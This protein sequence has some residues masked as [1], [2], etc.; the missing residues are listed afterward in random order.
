MAFGVRGRSG[1][2]GP[3]DS[4]V[5][6]NRAIAIDFGVSSLKVLQIAPGQPPSLVAAA[7][8]E[9]PEPLTTDAK[10]RLAFQCEALPRLIKSSKF[11]GKRAVCAIPA[12]MTF[13]KPLRLQ[14]TEGISMTD[15]VRGAVSAQLHCDP[16]AL[17]Y[18]HVEV[19]GVAG[20]KTEVICMAASREL[21][22]TLMGA[23][24]AAR[25]EPVGIHT[26]YMAA[27]CAFAPITRRA[28]DEHL[29]T[30]YLDLGAGTTKV[31]IAHGRR[32]VFAKG[33]ELG[34][35]RFD[36]TVARQ[37]NCGLE[38]AR[39]HRLAMDQPAPVAPE[40]ARTATG[41]M[42]LLSAGMRKEAARAP[43]AMAAVSERRTGG[44]P[45][46]HS[47]DLTTMRQASVAPP[48]ADLTEPLEMLTDEVQM[49]LRY[50]DSLFPGRR[51]D[52]AVF[53]GGEARNKGL[54]QHVARTLRVPAHVADPLAGMSRTGKEPTPGMDPGLAQP[55]WCVSVGLCMSPLDL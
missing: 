18:R 1:S 41:G 44:L 12:P 6:A 48:R 24:K 55:G 52:R 45:P 4:V 37:L 34:G 21:I 43:S 49:C 9:T 50:H 38:T 53:V 15:L 16:N 7:C 13:C 8:L 22:A 28:S 26:E 33:I 2:T 32:L 51:I 42:A 30:L 5:E 29:T 25:L 3:K 19:P 10:K 11:K 35:L 40:P 20:A 47:R 39:Q 46:G 31:M 27:L 23:V 14:R 54:C 36:E 17:V